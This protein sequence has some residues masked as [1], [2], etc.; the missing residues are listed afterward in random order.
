[1]TPNVVQHRIDRLEIAS[2]GEC[3]Y[4]GALAKNVELTDEHIIPFSLGGKAVIREGSCKECARET[5]KLENEIA[6]KVLWEFRAHV[7]SPTRRK[8]SR[9]TEL[10]FTYSIAGGERLTKSV[11][12]ADHPFFTPM[13]VWGRPG[14]LT[15]KLPTAEF[16]HYKAHVF[17]S[18]PPNIKQTLALSN[19]A[20]AELPF[21]EFRIDH[22]LY[23]RGI[24]RPIRLTQVP[25]VGTPGPN[26]RSLSVHSIPRW[27]PAR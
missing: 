5:A 18:V 21:P 24:G 13:P 11:P 25:Q 10:P 26:S 19:G 1:M 12:I 14:L 17:Y 9:P 6:H 22:N 20:L 7:R 4:C 15:G 16:E 2:F 27:M 23:A 8:K 3:I